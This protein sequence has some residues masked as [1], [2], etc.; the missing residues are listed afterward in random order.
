ML[1]ILSFLSTRQLKNG[2]A[3]CKALMSDEQVDR[4]T[5]DPWPRVI[6][7]FF[8]FN[9]TENEISTAH[10]IKVPIS[11]EVSCF[12]SL[13]CCIYHVNNVKMPTIVNIVTFM[14]RINFVLS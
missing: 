11:K 13:R 7:L 2:L 8:M 14:S 12:K 5:K 3:C 6:K 9:S 1:E 4:T 10:K